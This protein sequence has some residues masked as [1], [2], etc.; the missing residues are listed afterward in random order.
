ML[1]DWLRRRCHFG[2]IGALADH[3]A[4]AARNHGGC[5]GKHRDGSDQ[6]GARE[7]RL[8]RG[9]TETARG[10]CDSGFDSGHLSKNTEFG[11]KKRREIF[12]SRLF[13]PKSPAITARLAE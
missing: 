13:L 11:N 4:P 12:V 1:G 7:S 9:G 6:S 8:E 3:G 2:A 10:T 5:G